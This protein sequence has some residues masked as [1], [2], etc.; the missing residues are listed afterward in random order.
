MQRPPQIDPKTR[1]LSPLDR[2]VRRRVFHAADPNT[3]KPIAVTV[4]RDGGKVYLNAA[5]DSPLGRK[6]PLKKGEKLEVVEFVH[7]DELNGESWW[8]RTK[9]N[10][11][12][13]VAETVE[14]P[15]VVR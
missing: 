12:V 14:K 8:W 11:R 7:S 9:N 4:A 1:P 10:K 5:V 6:K 3:G 15:Y 2:I 13:N